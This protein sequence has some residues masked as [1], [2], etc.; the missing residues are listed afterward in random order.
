MSSLPI[1]NAPLNLASGLARADSAI[2]TVSA[3]ISSARRIDRPATD[4]AGIGQVARIEAEQIRLRAAEVNIQNGVSQLQATDSQ[5]STLGRIVT[6]LSELTTLGSDA[7][8]PAA[9]RAQ[10]ASEFTQLQTQLRQI[11]GGTSAEIGGL[12]DVERPLGRFNERELFGPGPGDTIAIGVEAGETVTLPVINLR[13]GPLGTLLRQDSSGNFVLSPASSSSS[14]ALGETLVAALSQLGEARA[15]AGATQSRLVF[16]AGVAEIANAN[17]EAALG[18][19][20]DADIA[21][22]TTQLARLQIRSEAHTS[23]LVQARE[24]TAKLL[25]LLA[26]N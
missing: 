17:R 6:R 15:S 21:A 16:A 19:I 23:M 9:D 18:A 3:R 13:Q 10:Y 4:G 24:V 7:T 1:G 12:S 22:E 5:L 25:P 8:R 20:Q 2:E 26:R 11:V 14:S